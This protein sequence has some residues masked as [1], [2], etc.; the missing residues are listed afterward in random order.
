M[1]KL[2]ILLGILALMSTGCASGDL[3]AAYAEGYAA[4]YD[5]AMADISAATEVSVPSAAATTQPQIEQTEPPAEEA[6][7]LTYEDP[8]TVEG[9][10]IV[11]HDGNTIAPVDNKY[12]DEYGVDVLR[13][14]LTI[15][16]H[17][18]STGMVY[19]GDFDFFGPNGTELNTIYGAYFDNDDIGNIGDLRNGASA[20]SC[21]Y[22][23]YD[24]NGDYY[25]EVEGGTG[26]VE[27]RL[28]VEIK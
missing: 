27:V 24:G 15:T 7:P 16:N 17:S 6:I 26:P 3:E 22:M 9:F 14:P 28:P 2:C 19:H 13:I 8:F 11:F 1:K 25:C 18:G 23:T 4:G 21:F 5:D 12:S 20:E 10:E